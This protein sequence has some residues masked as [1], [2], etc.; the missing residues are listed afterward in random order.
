MF[1]HVVAVLMASRC[2]CECGAHAI[3]NDGLIGQT[4]EYRDSFLVANSIVFLL[5]ASLVPLGNCLLESL[6]LQGN[7]AITICQQGHEYASIVSTLPCRLIVCKY[8]KALPPCWDFHS[9]QFLSFASASTAVGKTSNLFSS[10]HLL[11]LSC[12]Q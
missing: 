5:A 7:A 4:R 12:R 9:R 6:D 3:A 2:I 1:H 8:T 10:C 11:R